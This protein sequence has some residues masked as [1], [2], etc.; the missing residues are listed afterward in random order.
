MAAIYNDA[1]AASTGIKRNQPM[2]A[3]AAHTAPTISTTP[4]RSSRNPALT[5]RWMRTWPVDQALAL[6]PVPA[7]SMQTQLAA[8]AAGIPSRN[9][10]RPDERRVGEEGGRTRT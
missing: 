1:R 5:M 6:G 7:G 3:A 10:E 9:G 2:I 8:S 4:T